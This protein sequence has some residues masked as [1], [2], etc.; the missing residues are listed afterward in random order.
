MFESVKRREET[1]TNME[2]DFR[3]TK[4]RPASAFIIRRKWD[5]HKI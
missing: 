1:S 4:D 5:F 2:S 3:G